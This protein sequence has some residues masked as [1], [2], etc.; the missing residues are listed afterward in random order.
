MVMMK[1]RQTQL[2]VDCRLYEKKV[3]HLLLFGSSNFSDVTCKRNVYRY[4]NNK[5]KRKPE[6]CPVTCVNLI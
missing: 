2:R 5:K 6:E 4:G 1:T 3:L